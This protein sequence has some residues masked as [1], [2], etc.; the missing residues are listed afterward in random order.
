[1][2]GKLGSFA[3]V[4]LLTGLFGVVWAL[5]LARWMSVA[6]Y[7]AYAT[8][9]ASVGVA[10]IVGTLGVDRVLYRQLPAAHLGGA[11]GDVR[12]LLRLALAFR[13]M[14]APVAGA[15]IAWATARSA[16]PWG[17]VAFAAGLGASLAISDVLGI[18]ANA[19]VRFER[20]AQIVLGGLLLRLIAA[21]TVH[22]HFGVLGLEAALWISLCG[23][24]V[25]ALVSWH[26]AIRPTI[27]HVSNTAGTDAPPYRSVPLPAL[28]RSAL[29]N[30]T[31]YLVGLPWQGPTAIVL[32]GATSGTAEVA[33][34]GL[35]QGLLNRIRQYLPLQLLQN[36]FEPLLVRRY[37]IDRDSSVVAGGVDLLRRANF[38]L[39]LGAAAVAWPLGSGIVAA[40][41]RG[42]YLD[43]GPLAALMLAA[44]ALR[45]VSG[46]LFVSA[47]VMNEMGLLMR[48]YAV[49]TLIALVPL[50]WCAQRFGAPGVVLVSVVP[51]LLLWAGMRALHGRS[52]RGVWRWR[53][54]LRCLLAA[55]IALAAAYA[56]RPWAGNALLACGAALLAS[57]LYAGIVMMMRVFDRADLTLLRRS[58]AG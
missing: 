40:V 55:L 41:T 56:L 4:R 16:A 48:V 53:R 5:A 18:A 36:A 50:W 29:V 43:A 19:L 39:L 51:S 49:A 30:Y 28:A 20:Q 31:A 42:K 24:L 35:L 14:V 9:L 12:R 17:V 1:M 27:R 38:C 15:V 46:V 11:Y 23:D 54:D 34:F 52:A 7:A 13:L 58:A 2:T 21:G 6:S 37:A 57:A 25:Q 47:N 45:G 22:A 44:L 8:V 26:V 3:A 10:A 32:V 33:L